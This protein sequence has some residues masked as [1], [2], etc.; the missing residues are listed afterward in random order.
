MKPLDHKPLDNCYCNDCLIYHANKDRKDKY[1][2]HHSAKNL[3]ILYRAVQWYESQRKQGDFCPEW[4]YAANEAV[5]P[6]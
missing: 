4:V 1:S 6:E 3:D 2:R 5:N